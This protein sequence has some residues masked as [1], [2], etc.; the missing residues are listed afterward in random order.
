M[1]R[2]KRIVIMR[3]NYISEQVV[4]AV[5]SAILWQKPEK[6]EWADAFSAFWEPSSYNVSVDLSGHGGRVPSWRVAYINRPA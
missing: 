2:V 4:K 5:S 6:D 1:K 3:L